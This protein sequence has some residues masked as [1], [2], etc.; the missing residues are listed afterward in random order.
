[1]VGCT[2]MSLGWDWWQQTHKDTSKKYFLTQ[3][4]SLTV[5]LFNESYS[6]DSEQVFVVFLIMSYFCLQLFLVLF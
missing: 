3:V 1:M 4:L 6:L 2:F 5:V